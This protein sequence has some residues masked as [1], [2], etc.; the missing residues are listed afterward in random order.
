MCL[1]RLP[2]GESLRPHLPNTAKKPAAETGGPQETPESKREGRVREAAGVSAVRQLPG[3]H[4]GS[5]SLLQD[6]VRPQIHLIRRQKVAHPLQLL[7]VLLLGLWEDA[8][9]GSLPRCQV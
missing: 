6:R 4:L 2:E 9:R 3:L 8:L 1:L 7:T 5:P